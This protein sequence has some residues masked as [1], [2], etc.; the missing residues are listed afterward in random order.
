MARRDFS[1]C[2]AFLLILFIPFS[3]LLLSPHLV[4]GNFGDI[5]AYHYPLRHLVTSTLQ[6]GRLPLWNPYIFAGTPLAANPQAVLFYPLSA[7]HHFFPLAWSIS[8]EMFF[9]LFWAWF[10]AYL[11]LRKWALDRAGAWTLAFAYA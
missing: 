8:V 4:P 1:L 7:V 2:A 10:G 9:H 11:L 6:E 5:Y 3:W